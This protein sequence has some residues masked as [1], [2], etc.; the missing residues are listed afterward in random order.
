MN[1]HLIPMGLM[2]VIGIGMGVLAIGSKAP[3][4]R[5]GGTVALI[6]TVSETTPPTTDNAKSP[7]RYPLKNGN[8]MALLAKPANTTGDLGT[9]AVLADLLT[10]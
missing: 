5:N 6:I 3:P 9:V 1:A 2:L 7:L 4:E 8:V 10:E